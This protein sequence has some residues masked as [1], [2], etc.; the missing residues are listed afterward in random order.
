M[1]H[2]YLEELERR[3]GDDSRLSMSL[4]TQACD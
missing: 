2:C 3:E 4:T 1:N